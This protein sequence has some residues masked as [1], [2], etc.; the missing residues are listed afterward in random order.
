[1]Q[2]SE[3]WQP[4]DTQIL[5]LWDTAEKQEREKH[6]TE[7]E[8]NNGGSPSNPHRNRPN[9][10]TMAANRDTDSMGNNRGN[11][12]NG[13]R[14]ASGRGPQRTIGTLEPEVSAT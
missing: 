6:G 1:M 3:A 14:T 13:Y 11:S 9:G 10:S 2:N 12:G 7:L 5:E 8:N 4:T